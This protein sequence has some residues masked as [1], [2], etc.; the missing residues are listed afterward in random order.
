MGASDDFDPRLDLDKAPSYKTSVL[1]NMP[2][3]LCEKR[4]PLKE[5][6]IFLIIKLIQVRVTP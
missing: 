3:F 4:K 5:I 1:K 2:Y 6:G